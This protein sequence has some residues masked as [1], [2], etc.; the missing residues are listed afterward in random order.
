MSVLIILN[1]APYGNERS[2]NGLRLAMALGKKEAPVTVFL[3]ADAVACA[4]QGQ[5]VPQ[6]YY[7]IER[8]LKAVLH[9]GEVLLCGSCT[10]TRGL[11]EEEV[12]R[13]ARRSTMDELAERTLNADKILV[14]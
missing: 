2:Y 14:F 5:K 13:G 6:G 9:N 4:K 11:A 12:V 1:E 3:I 8:M 10:D 7:S